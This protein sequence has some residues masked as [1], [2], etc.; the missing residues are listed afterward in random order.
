M[1]LP[2]LEGGT[3]ISARFERIEPRKSDEG[4]RFVIHTFEYRSVRL[5]DR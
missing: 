4:A 2:P 1:K 3:T 5:Y